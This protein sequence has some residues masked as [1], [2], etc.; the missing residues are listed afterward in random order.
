MNPGPLLT[1]LH[2]LENWLEHVEDR[3]SLLPLRWAGRTLLIGVVLLSN[4]LALVRWPF[5]ALARRLCADAAAGEEATT[6]ENGSAASGS[7]LVPGIAP[8]EPIDVDEEKLSR[9]IGSGRRVLVDFWAEWCGP[10]LMI[11]GL[12]DEVAQSSSKECVVAKV[13]TVAHGDLT[14]KHGVKGLPTL[15]LFE[16]GEEVRR[17]AGTLS[18]AE[19]TTLVEGD[20]GSVADASGH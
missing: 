9:L 13:N 15:I 7:V 14:E 3:R 2:A 1:R 18:R 19:L 11:E 17:H 10:C 5:A 12:L 20:E 4:L 16:H 8:D 6:G